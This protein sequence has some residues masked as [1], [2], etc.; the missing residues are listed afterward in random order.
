M[1]RKPRGEEA[2]DG[3]GRKKRLRDR[4]EGRGWCEER[5]YR[6]PMPSSSYLN[7]VTYFV[8]VEQTHFDGYTFVI[9][10][11]LTKIFLHLNFWN[12]F[13]QL[14]LVMNRRASLPGVKGE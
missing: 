4:T 12:G 3:S 10:Y 2:S 7:F 9:L 5:R 8:N 13:A 14:K 1:R 11:S 6:E